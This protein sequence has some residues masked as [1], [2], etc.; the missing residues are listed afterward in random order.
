MALEIVRQPEHC[1]VM[2]LS[3]IEVYDRVMMIIIT[4]TVAIIIS[5][6]VTTSIIRLLWGSEHHS[7]QSLKPRSKPVA[8]SERGRTRETHWHRVEFRVSGLGFR[9][10]GLGFRFTN[11]T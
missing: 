4:V 7:E 8:G 2:I 5:V 11:H 9:V 6:V 10:W 3:I 1:L